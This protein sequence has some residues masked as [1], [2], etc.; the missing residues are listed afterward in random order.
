MWR[1]A[2]CARATF[3]P[4]P[5]LDIRP[6]RE[7]LGLPRAGKVTLLRVAWFGFENRR[8][9]VCPP[10][11]SARRAGVGSFVCGIACQIL[12][13]TPAAGGGAGAD[14]ALVII[15]GS[16]TALPI[17]ERVA[18]AWTHGRGAAPAPP[19]R[20]RPAQ[21]EPTPG[22]ARARRLLIGVSGTRSGIDRLCG[23]QVH[24]A[25]ASR[26]MSDDERRRCMRAGV[27][28]WEFPIAWDGIAVVV[29]PSNSFA[30]A[31]TTR[32]LRLIF[33]PASQGRIVRWRQ[34]RQ[35]WPDTPIHLYG[36]GS[37][38]GTYEAFTRAILGEEGQSR[39][40]YTASED[41]HRLVQAMS[42]DPSALGFLGL[43]YFWQARGRL[44]SVAIDDEHPENGVGAIAPSLDS[45]Q[46]GSYQPLSRLLYAYVR[47]SSPPTH[48][49]R[50]FAEELLRAGPTH[51]TSLGYVPLAAARYQ[52]SLATLRGTATPQSP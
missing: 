23:G 46:Q 48:A 40:D 33:A 15:D 38:S 49:L 36:A 31:L 44:R 30:H 41:D 45:V 32:E 1:N 12:A 25:M 37:G 52:A 34:V 18:H 28:Y 21:E 20:D 19:A 10:R 29:H 27:P 9:G 39:G 51:M 16:S 7:T 2:H 4:V 47:A 50:S 26:P 14:E 24:V 3:P 6:G 5:A 22:A 11:P 43:T 35:E 42:S 17:V 8:G 13:C